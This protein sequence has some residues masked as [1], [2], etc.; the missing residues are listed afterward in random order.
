MALYLVTRQ[1]KWHDLNRGKSRWCGNHRPGSIEVRDVSI[2]KK[3][4]EKKKINSTISLAFLGF[5]CLD[6]LAIINLRTF[7]LFL[8]TGISAKIYLSSN[9]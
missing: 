7:L 4:I 9:W 3:S 8:V 1:W 5:L 2:I 6:K